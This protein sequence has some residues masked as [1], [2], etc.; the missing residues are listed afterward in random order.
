M[1]LIFSYF[2]CRRNTFSVSTYLPLTIYFS[3]HKLEH[4]N[5]EFDKS[6]QVHLHF[7]NLKPCLHIHT[8][9]FS[10]HNFTEEICLFLWALTSVW[11]YYINKSVYCLHLL[12][13]CVFKKLC[14]WRHYFQKILL[15]YWCQLNDFLV[16]NHFLSSR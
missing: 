14:G 16:V 5:I 4:L 2:F 7:G 11:L 6:L 10:F 8:Y 15:S 13:C 3:W 1:I 12:T 9:I